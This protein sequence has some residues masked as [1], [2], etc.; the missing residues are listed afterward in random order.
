ML[1]GSL[2]SGY[3]VMGS[4]YPMLWVVIS[5]TLMGSYFNHCI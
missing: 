4:Y 5:S 3:Y 1:V 2:I